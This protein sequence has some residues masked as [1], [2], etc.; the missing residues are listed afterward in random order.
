LPL[1]LRVNLSLLFLRRL[2]YTYGREVID[3]TVTDDISRDMEFVQALVHEQDDRLR[4]E[5]EKWA[6]L[7]YTS[8]RAVINQRRELIL[9]LTR[10][11]SS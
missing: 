7:T 10:K 6:L 9:A 11:H 5:F 4:K 8:N 3:Q 1:I 2:K